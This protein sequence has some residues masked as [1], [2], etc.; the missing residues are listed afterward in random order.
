MGDLQRR[1]SPRQGQAHWYRLAP[2]FWIGRWG[3]VHRLRCLQSV[4]WQEAPDSCPHML[5]CVH[6]HSRP[7]E[8]DRHERQ[9]K[10]CRGRRQPCASEVYAPGRGVPRHLGIE[11]KTTTQ[12][13][14]C[15]ELFSVV[16]VRD[17]SLLR[18][19]CAPTTSTT[20]NRGIS[21][22]RL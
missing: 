17:G 20:S 1:E 18:F 19:M 14:A 3:Q 12:C 6:L 9:R 11:S 7:V 8:A 13:S 16:T 22:G 15:P 4:V 21:R 2:S 10:W 5:H